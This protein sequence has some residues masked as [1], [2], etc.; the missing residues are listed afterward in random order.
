ME[1]RSALSTDAQ[2]HPPP[3]NRVAPRS[4]LR[5]RAFGSAVSLRLLA[6]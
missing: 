6:P 3:R 2:S 4:S 1:G 5:T